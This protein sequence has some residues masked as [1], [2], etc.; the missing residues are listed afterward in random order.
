MFNNKSFIREGNLLIKGQDEVINR[1]R[2]KGK[3]NVNVANKCVTIK[4]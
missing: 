2:K 4:K 1:V 3:K